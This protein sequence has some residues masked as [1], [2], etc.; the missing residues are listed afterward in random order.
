MSQQAVKFI[1][2]TKSY[3]P[4]DPKAF[5]EAMGATDREDGSNTKVPITA[6]E[7]YNFLPTS[8][9]YKSYFGTTAKLAV[10]NLAANVDHIFILQNQAYKNIVIALTDRGIFTKSGNSG[11][12]WTQATVV[13]P[14]DVDGVHYEWSYVIISDVLYCYQQNKGTYQKITSLASGLGYTLTNVTPNFL[15]MTAQMGI[16]RAGARLGFW[17]SDNSI[18]WSNQD[19][20]S[21]FTPS[22][23]TL[24]GNVKFLQI[25][26][27][28]VTIRPH[29][30]GFIIYCTRSIVYVQEATE[31]TFSWNP[32]TILGNTGIAYREEANVGV[33]DTTHFA[34]TNTGLYKITKASP[35]VIVP[36]VTDYLKESKLPVYPK[37]MEGRFLFL[38]L[39]DKD[40]ID[41]LVGLTDEVVPGDSYVF[42]GSGG[43]LESATEGITI[44]GDS[45]CS[46]LENAS[47]G[48]YDDQQA[49]AN[50]IAMPGKKAGTKA[51]PVWTCYI[52]NN[53]PLN[54]D[55]I[56]FGSTP[57]SVVNLDGVQQNMSPQGKGGRLDSMTQT[58]T[59]KKALL[60]SDVYVDG[61]WTMERFI[62]LQTAIWEK[63]EKNVNAYIAKI[64]G[65]ANF[66]QKSSNVGSCAE[67]A[68]SQVDCA[69]GRYVT[70]YSPPQFGYSACAFW[71]T[72]FAVGA[73]DIKTRTVNKT[74][75][76]FVPLQTVAPSSIKWRVTGPDLTTDYIYPDATTACKV[77]N[78]AWFGCG[79]PSPG[80]SES[81]CVSG[82]GTPVYG[83]N[84]IA[85]CPADFTPR[86]DTSGGVS[87]YHWVCDKGAYYIKD[88]Y[89]ST[90][91]VG[92]YAEITPTPETA[93][94]EI[95]G[96]KYQKDDGSFATVAASSCVSPSLFPKK[97]NTPMKAPAFRANNDSKPSP[98]GQNGTICSK[99]FD[100]VTVPGLPVSNVT[101]PTTEVDIP[102]GSFLLQDGSIAPLYP[103]F[104]GALVY[105][106]QLKK[107]GKYKGKYKQ[108][109]DYSPINNDAKGGVTYATFGM[110]S[111]VLKSNGGIYLFDANPQD[112]YIKYG[113]IGY[114]R[115]G[116]TSVQEAR[117]H[118]RS[119]ST[120]TIRVESSYDGLSVGSNLFVETDFV[121]AMQAE[122]D[123]GYDGRWHNIKISGKF[124][125]Q[126]LEYRGFIRGKR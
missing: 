108:L 31:T 21:D 11:G 30:E 111:G 110:I 3:L 1:E 69:L 106:L 125:I 40:Y 44:R 98:S 109:L 18:G 107:W 49:L 22:L 12:A 63:E 95:T 45:F 104:E 62:Q 60:G 13:V 75:C 93:Y 64:L 58:S 55:D 120:G 7:G 102:P 20:Y 96:W 126:Y 68:R 78:P 32:I 79:T 117:V 57:C 90:E 100:P 119:K 67:V 43:S 59:N 14:P 124:D 47:N 114:Y 86:V 36:E 8:Y 88:Q 16:F 101:W 51:T 82:G 103:D 115:L 72:R 123:G 97:D 99:P 35:E 77:V 19:D 71:L 122:S 28:I 6:Y 76:T 81:C 24:A 83:A 4:I 85:T 70:E 27:R 113:K 112:S 10:D 41:G 66:Q 17:D 46:V 92:E 33:P 56:T 121:D 73:M 34:Y 29:G 15:N 37:I 61:I 53:A 26:G 54:P 94:C 23:E 50:S 80:Y 74:I 87:N 84:T 118:F 5:P 42:P 39:L 89:F 52:S 65:K 25:V 38:Q 91:N 9:G 105:D 116:F 2:V 48:N